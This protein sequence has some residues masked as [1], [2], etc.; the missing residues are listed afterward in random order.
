MA[1]LGCHHT[2]LDIHIAISRECLPV[3]ADACLGSQVFTG[4]SRQACDMSAGAEYEDKGCAAL[5]CT[6]LL[7]T[8]IQLNRINLPFVF[9]K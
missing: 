6:K 7:Y 2:H 5:T 3:L 4:T 9:H 1:S 8:I